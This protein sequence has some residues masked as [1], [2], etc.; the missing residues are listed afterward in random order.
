VRKAFDQLAKSYNVFAGFVG[1]RTIPGWQ[2]IAAEK[3]VE[4][5]AH[6]E[7]LIS[8]ARELMAKLDAD[9]HEVSTVTTA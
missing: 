1:S 9:Q 5:E 6:A 8:V 4:I 7:L 2:R 3:T